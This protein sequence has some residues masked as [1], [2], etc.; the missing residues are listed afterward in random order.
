MVIASIYSNV[1]LVFLIYIG[2]PKNS[3]PVSSAYPAHGMCEGY[4]CL[5]WCAV[6]DCVTQC[7]CVCVY[8]FNTM[9]VV[10]YLIYIPLRHLCCMHCMLVDLTHSS[11]LLYCNCIGAIRAAAERG[12]IYD[13]DTEHA[14]FNTLRVLF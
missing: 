11:N 14:L 2:N 6:H 4:S 1:F 5:M 3:C 7:V 10:T 13:I 9:I 8:A 12:H